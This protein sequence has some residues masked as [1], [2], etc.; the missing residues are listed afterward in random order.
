MVYPN[1]SNTP[2]KE[3]VFAI[4][5]DEIA[6]NVGFEKF[7]NLKEIKKRFP[8][9]NA[10][11]SLQI[12]TGAKEKV[13]SHQKNGYHLKNENEVVHLRKGSLSYHYLNNYRKFEDMVNTVLG[14]WQVFC[15]ESELKLTINAV[16]VRYINEIKIDGDNLESRLIQLYPKQSSDRKVYNFQNVVTFKYINETDY[17]VNVVSTKPAEDKVL[18]DI[19][20]INQKVSKEDKIENMFYPLQEIKNRVFF[21]SITAQALVKYI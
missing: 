9:I 6:D 7:V 10:S 19:T 16:S 8:T 21:D 3:I 1:L 2:I 18:L 4:S 14:L 17:L 11:M 15:Q 5:Y 13:V 20:V 12:L